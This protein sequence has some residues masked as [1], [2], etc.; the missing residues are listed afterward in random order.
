MDEKLHAQTPAKKTQS[1]IKK[2]TLFP[3]TEL[4]HQHTGPGRSGTLHL[5]TCSEHDAPSNLIKFPSYLPG[6]DKQLEY[7]ASKVSSQPKVF[8]LTLLPTLFYQHFP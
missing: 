2:K 3:M 5:S 7:M 4:K 8:S 1:E 6:L